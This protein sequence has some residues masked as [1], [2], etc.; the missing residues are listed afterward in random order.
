[1]LR[2]PR[3]VGALALVG[4]VAAVAFITSSRVAEAHHGVRLDHFKCYLAQDPT[5]WNAPV[6]LSDQFTQLQTRVLNAVR[7]CNPTRKIHAGVPT[8]VLDADAHLTIYRLNPLPPPITRDIIAANQFGEQRLRV[9]GPVLL[10]VPTQKRGHEAPRNLDHFLC[11]RAS[12]TPLNLQVWLQDQFFP[13]VVPVTS[14][15]LF[16]NPTKKDHADTTTPILHPDEHL[17]CYLIQGQSAARTIGVRN[18]FGVEALPLTNGNLLC[19]PSKKTLPT[20]T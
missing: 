16:C 15:A 13:E 6:T 17:T 3:L 5:P 1:M 18:Q 2:I 8:P 9:S 4:V 19:A 20:G 11:Y 10:A 12:G 14:P 7:F